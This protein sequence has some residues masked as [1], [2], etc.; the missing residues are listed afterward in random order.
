MPSAGMPNMLVLDRPSKKHSLRHKRHY[1][2]LANQI[3]FATQYVIFFP[4]CIS[5]TFVAV[6]VTLGLF[7]VQ[8][9]LKTLVIWI[10]LNIYR[11]YAEMGVAFFWASVFLLNPLSMVLYLWLL[12]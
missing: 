12:L 4:N 8:T 1:R 9:E 3:V 10:K 2:L 7:V 11:A 5:W 6:A